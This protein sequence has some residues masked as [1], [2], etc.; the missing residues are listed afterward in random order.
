MSASERPGDVLASFR[1]DGRVAVVTGAGSGL[2]RAFAEACGEA[3]ADVACVDL[4]EAAARLTAERIAT[5]G[6]RAIA[7]QAD[8]AAEDAV[9]EAFRRIDEELAPADIAFANAGIAGAAGEI[10][11]WTLDQ[12]NEVIGVNLTGVFLTIRAAAR[13]MTPRGYGKIIVTGSMY[14]VTGD[15]FFGAHGYAAAKGGVLSLVRTSANR[16]APKGVRVN[17]I[18]PGYIRTNIAGG[19]MFSGD[20]EAVRL[21]QTLAARIPLGALGEPTDLKGIAVFLASAASDYC[22]G[23]AFPVDGGWLIS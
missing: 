7:V 8:V 13:R 2:G 22:T 11:D 21:R 6:V 3:G 23:A 18:L 4:D 15:P 16:L 9:E 5:L 1:L 17:A 19:H 10:E 12:W 14:S 20:P